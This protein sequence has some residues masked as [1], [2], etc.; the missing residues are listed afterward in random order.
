M[1]PGDLSFGS[2]KRHITKSC[3]P[4]NHY[5]GISIFIEIEKISNGL[6]NIME[7]LDID[8]EH[9]LALAE[10]AER[11]C[12]IRGNQSIDHI[13]SE[14]YSIGETRKIS[15]LKVKS[16]E[17]LLFLSDSDVTEYD[18]EVEYL[19]QNQV[20]LVK[21][22]QKFITSD[23]CRHFTIKELAERFQI[24]PTAMKKNFK[25]VYGTSIYAYLRIYRLQTA[26][27]L[28]MNSDCGIAEIAHKIG[29]ENPNKFASAF[30]REYGVTPTEFRKSVRLDRK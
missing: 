10:N 8:M 28:L 27:K 25:S 2:L 18:N 23:I 21:E 7:L 6:R 5:H 29:Y 1:T 17:L 22:V 3:F 16:L 14:L 13:F 9:I 11:Y 24:S 15:Y 30:K 20:R 26:Q 19:N 4:L 12:I